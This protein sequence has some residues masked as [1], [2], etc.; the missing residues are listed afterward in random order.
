MFVDQT[1]VLYYLLHNVTKLTVYL[2]TVW[3]Q[4]RRRVIF[5]NKKHIIQMKFC[6]ASHIFVSFCAI[7]HELFSTTLGYYNLY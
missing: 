5:E 1:V 2:F 4:I 6:F 7:L 3:A